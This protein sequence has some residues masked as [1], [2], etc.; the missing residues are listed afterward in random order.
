MPKGVGIVTYANAACAA[1]RGTA[2]R[3]SAAHR[4]P[5]RGRGAAGLHLT[6][7]EGLL[8]GERALA[9]QLEGVVQ[10]LHRAL[11][12]RAVDHA[13]DL[14]RRGGDHFDVHVLAGEYAEQRRRNP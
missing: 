9:A 4:R 13:R 11:D 12:A 8:L 1:P 2:W 7:L 10:D 5:Q 6:S 3:L 14:D